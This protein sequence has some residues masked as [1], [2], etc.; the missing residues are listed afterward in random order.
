MYKNIL[1]HG[2]T[3]CGSSNYGDYIYGEMIYEFFKDKK[4]NVCF[5]Q[6]SDFFKNNLK[7]SDSQT[8]KKNKADLIVYIP[9]GY[10]G[11]GHNSKFKENLVQFLRFM[12]LGIWASYRKT[13]MIVL[14]IGAG[15]IN[16]ILMKFGIKRICNNSSFV[17][18]RDNESYNSLQSLCPKANIIECG[19]LILT[20][21]IKKLNTDTEQLK[22]IIDIK[23]DKKIV[24]VHYNHDK[25]ALD[26]FAECLNDFIR[27]NKDYSVV[28]ASDSILEYDN[29]YYEL[30]KQK[31]Q[32]DSVHFIYEDPHEMTTL[33]EK[34]DIVLTCKLHV[35]VVASLYG[36]S[37]IAAACHPEKTKR[38]YEQI[39]QPDRCVSLYESNN[40]QLVSLLEKYKDKSI[41]IED[42]I[43]CNACKS[44]E[45]LEGFIGDKNEK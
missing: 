36:K 31:F 4:Y 33:L 13:P 41:K 6:P 10:F 25:Y 12:P 23:K 9:G 34:V 39:N 26:R 1:L 35:G 45:I 21:D 15:P 16:N 37:V 19:D 28:V 20:R 43:I 32:H 5:Y 3:N 40:D 42:K 29:E 7:I 44:W 27:N 22:E 8:F 11:E 24:L 14:G 2:A 30:F 18:V 38:F 17:T